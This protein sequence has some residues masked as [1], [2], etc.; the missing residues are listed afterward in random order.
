L[1]AVLSLPA[2]GSHV[3]SHHGNA[4]QTIFPEQFLN[5]PE[6]EILLMNCTLTTA[7]TGF[8]PIFPAIT[9]PDPFA[10]SKSTLVFGS[11]FANPR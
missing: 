1:N 11:S 3:C 10:L 6:C 9:V 8:E 7:C 2:S 5:S 4:H